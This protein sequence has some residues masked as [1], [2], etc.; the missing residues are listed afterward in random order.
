MAMA[1]ADVVPDASFFELVANPSNLN[2]LF[3]ATSAGVLR[4]D[5]GGTSWYRYMEGLPKVMDVR[6]IE[7]SFD[8]VDE[9]ELVIGTNGRGWWRRVIDDGQFEPQVFADG[10]ESGDLSAWAQ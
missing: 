9:P 8:G 4:S 2:Q 5:N 10:F 6:Q 3:L 7:L 1:F